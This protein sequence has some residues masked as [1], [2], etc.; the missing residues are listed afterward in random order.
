VAS[1]HEK[2]A[3]KDSKNAT[4]HSTHSDERKR[5]HVVENKENRTRSL[6]TLKEVHRAEKLPGFGGLDG[7]GAASKIHLSQG[8]VIAGVVA[9][10]TPEPPETRPVLW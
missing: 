3:K 10:Q 6:D 4:A 1:W 7:S 2:R 9:T 5:I 8:N